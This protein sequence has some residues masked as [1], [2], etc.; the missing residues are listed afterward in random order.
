[1]VHTSIFAKPRNF[2]SQKIFAIQYMPDQ[3]IQTHGTTHLVTS[4]QQVLDISRG[5]VANLEA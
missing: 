1:M 4:L 3:D 5:A 2:D